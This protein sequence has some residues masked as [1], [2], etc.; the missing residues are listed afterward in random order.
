LTRSL[1]KGLQQKLLATAAV[2]NS[3]DELGME[4]E[5]FAMKS[6]P[7]RLRRLLVRT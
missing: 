2:K 4:K 3:C 5:D 7:F 6:R 1:H